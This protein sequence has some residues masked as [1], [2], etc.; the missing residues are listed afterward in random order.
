VPALLA[1]VGV[2]SSRAAFV[3]LS[4]F[5]GGAREMTSFG[6]DAPPQTDD[7]MSLEFTAVRAMYA[8]P[9]GHAARLKS[10]ASGAGPAIVSD[11]IQRASAADWTARGTA[12][13]QAKAAGMALD[14]FRRALEFDSRSPVA[15]RGLTDAAVQ[16]RSLSQEIEWLKTRAAAE[17]GNVAVRVEL[18][19]VLASLGHTGDAV[20]AARDA[21]LIDPSRP[22]PLEQLA[23][24]FADEGDAPQLGPLADELVKRFPARDDGRYYQATALFLAGRGQEAEGPLRLL[25]SANPRHAKGQ[26]LLGVVCGSLG[27]PDCAGAAFAAAAELD[28]RDPSVYVNLGYLRLAG[29]DAA[30][31]ADFF[32]EA[33]AVD[34]TSEAARRGLAEA[35]GPR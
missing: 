15:L 17:P 33:L 14:S 6:D 24:I 20:A 19:H 5:T 13:L 34:T 30:G 10:L 2:P 25:L 29:G 27:R 11:S 4:M 7:R 35:R 1:D 18:A 12:A 22:E 23:S 31:A 26:N 32:G 9:E 28:P 3:L 16:A 8:P 21:A